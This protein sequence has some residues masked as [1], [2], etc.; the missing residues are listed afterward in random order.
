LRTTGIIDLSRALQEG[1]D[2]IVESGGGWVSSGTSQVGDIAATSFH[3]YFRYLREN[4]SLVVLLGHQMNMSHSSLQL[5]VEVLDNTCYLAQVFYSRLQ[6]ENRNG[7]I[8][9]I[10]S[11]WLPSILASPLWSLLRLLPTGL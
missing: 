8:S 6:T 7:L 3:Q 11:D 5:S 1:A 10:I 9:V 4:I 2:Q